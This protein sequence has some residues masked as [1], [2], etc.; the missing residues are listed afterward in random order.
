MI[1]YFTEAE[2]DG[3]AFFTERLPQHDLRFAHTPDDVAGDAEALC[4]FIRTG[5][6]AAFLA[7]RPRLR[8]VCTRSTGVD[9]IDLAACRARGITVCR[10]PSYGE[11]TV[12]EHTFALLLALSRHLL[13]FMIT[14]Q[15]RTFSYADIRGFDLCGRTLGI[16]GM[17]QIGQGVA[18]IAAGF[19][20]RVLACDIA[21]QEDVARELGF[22]YTSFDT[23]LSQ[24]DIVSL[25]TGLSDETRHMLDRA[26]LARCRPGVIIINTARGGL[27]DTAALREALDSGQVAGAGLDVL[28]DERVLREP[29]AS[30]IAR[31]ISEH[32]REARPAP[33]AHDPARIRELEQLMHDDALLARPNVV[34]TPHVAF[35]SIEA[36]ARIRDVTLE[37]IAAFA[38]G[39]AVNVV[40]QE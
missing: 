5:I 35:N 6:D 19:R 4:C 7:A 18:R 31:D 39:C 11:T 37:S 14:P 3:V 27:I 28:E 25:H 29:A 24:S 38:A 9:H 8:L 34:F 22:T 12:A 1:L 21:P 33:E 10:V 40:E 15:R 13:E 2:P 16:V 32:L 23:L 30:I 36:I 20:M 26:A 17:G